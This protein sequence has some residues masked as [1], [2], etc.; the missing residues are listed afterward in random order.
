MDPLNPLNDAHLAQMNAAIT[1][2]ELAL[3]GLAKARLAGINVD[4][5]E[6]QLTDALARLRQLKTVYFPGR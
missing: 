6:N 2:G 1:S 5:H 4:L 3:Q